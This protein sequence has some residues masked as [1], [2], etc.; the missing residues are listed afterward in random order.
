MAL[1]EEERIKQEYDKKISM[2]EKMEEEMVNRL[3][4]IGRVPKIAMSN[5]SQ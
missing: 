3:R 1:N 5:S 2:M 4:Q